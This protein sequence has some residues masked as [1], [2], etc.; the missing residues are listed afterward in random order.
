[1]DRLHD[2]DHRGCAPNPEGVSWL[3]HLL[4]L[5]TPQMIPP[6]GSLTTLCSQHSFQPMKMK[7]PTHWG[8]AKPLILWVH[9]SLPAAPRAACALET[10]Q[11]TGRR[12][13]SHNGWRRQGRNTSPGQ[14]LQ[15]LLATLLALH[16]GRNEGVLSKPELWNSKGESER[17]RT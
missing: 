5:M 10:A 3:L 4:T 2:A 9:Q 6:P 12:G 14:M 1:M 17:K 13:H 11:G 16:A 8:S 15:L 7:T